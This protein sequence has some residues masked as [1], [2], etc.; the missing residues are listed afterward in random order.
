MYEPHFTSLL[1][2]H[3]YSDEAVSYFHIEFIIIKNDNHIH[4]NVV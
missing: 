2:S 1:R 4:R 3:L